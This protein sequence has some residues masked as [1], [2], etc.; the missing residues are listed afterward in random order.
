MYQ[1]D[2][3]KSN[4]EMLDIIGEISDIEKYNLNKTKRIFNKLLFAYFG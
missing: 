2:G 1:I 4:N 3:K